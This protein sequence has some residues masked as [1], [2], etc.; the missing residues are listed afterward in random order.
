MTKLLPITKNKS[1]MKFDIT[2]NSKNNSFELLD[3]DLIK[4]TSKKIIKNTYH[5]I[6]NTKN[7]E[8]DDWQLIKSKRNP[9]KIKQNEADTGTG[10]GTGTDTGIG[11][12]H[13][14]DYEHGLDTEPD[15]LLQPVN[16]ENLDIG[17]D[18]KF[19]HSY[20]IWVHNDSS[21]WSI[22]GFDGDF[23]IIDSVSTFLQFFNNFHKFD[24]NIYS[25]YIMKSLDNNTFIEPTW[26]HIY[27]RNGGTCS[28]RIDIIHGLGLLAQLCLLMVN[29]CLIPDMSLIN[30]IS[31]NKKTNW[32]LIKIWT[33]DKETDIHKLLPQVIISSY[34]NICIKSKINS[35]E[36]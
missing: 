36:Y 25:F 30:G 2:S 12:K 33:K 34:P 28:L 9:K 13:E 6:N 35:P 24:L 8:T 27:N 3:P 26:E 4:D 7:K 14:H 20:K 29:E 1:K 5:K 15:N 10:T 19:K 22:N 21:D 17:K 32:A 23:F 16:N 18:L 11:T 31:I